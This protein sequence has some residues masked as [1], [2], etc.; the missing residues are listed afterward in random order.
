MAASRIPSSAI[1]MGGVSLPLFKLSQLFFNAGN[2]IL[3]GW[4]QET[5]PLAEYKAAGWAGMMSLPRVLSLADDGG[6]R[7]SVS[8]EVNQLRSRE[9]SLTVTADDAQNKHHLESL[10]IAACCGEILCAAKRASE[11][12]ELVLSGSG[13]NAALW[14]TLGY[15]PNH[16]QQVL[17]DARPILVVH[18]EKE[19]LEFHL[20][21]DGSVIEVFVNQQT[22]CTKRFYYGGKRPQNLRL[23][24]TGSTANIARLSV[25]Q[26]TPI[27][28]NRLTT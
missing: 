12:F 17:I 27:S 1:H 21:V 23:H 13:K 24:W 28:P 15:D 6:L 3:W 9:Q 5:R 19:D 20:Y 16:P 11:P 2:R 22:A 4:I 8:P 14:P 7:F 18:D 26:F 10:R 25:W